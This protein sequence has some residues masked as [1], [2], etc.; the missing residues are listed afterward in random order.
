[1]G[2]STCSGIESLQTT[3]WRYFI[4]GTL[5]TRDSSM[6]FPLRVKKSRSASSIVAVGAVAHFPKR[7]TSCC[8]FAFEFWPFDA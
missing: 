5:P 2:I 6:F 4:F 3:P 7:C 1:M 8:T